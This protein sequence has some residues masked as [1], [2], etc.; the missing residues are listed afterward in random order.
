MDKSGKSYLKRQL[1]TFLNLG[2]PAG[3][4]GGRAVENSGRQEE[5]E[6]ISWISR[7][8]RDGEQGEVKGAGVSDLHRGPLNPFE[9]L[10]TGKPLWGDS[11]LF[12]GSF[13]IR[14]SCFI[15]WVG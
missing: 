11:Y 6:V 12:K 3:R 4:V 8:A 9:F 1:I 14:M 15:T 2:S 13:K 7:W 5:R 10:K